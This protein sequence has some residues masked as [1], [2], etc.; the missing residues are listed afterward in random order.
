MHRKGRPE[1]RCATPHG[2]VQGWF[3]PSIQTGPLT[4][5]NT[6][7]EMPQA[8][9]ADLLPE[10]RA[11]ERPRPLSLSP[12]GLGEGGTPLRLWSQDHRKRQQATH[13]RA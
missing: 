12:K 2:Q 10:T 5:Q 13:A 6:C 8:L 4:G 9:S 7:C 1:T 11:L 3:Y